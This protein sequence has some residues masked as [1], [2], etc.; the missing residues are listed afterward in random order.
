[1]FKKALILTSD[2]DQFDFSD[3]NIDVYNVYEKYKV[4]LR[5]IRRI[6]FLMNFPFKFLWY[7]N[8]KNRIEEYDFIVVDDGLFG[9]ELFS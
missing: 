3:N 2:A 1:M 8:W 4:F 6:W 7:G 9:M 5:A